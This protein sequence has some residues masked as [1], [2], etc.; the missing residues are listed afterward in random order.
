MVNIVFAP[1]LWCPNKSW[2]SVPTPTNRFIAFSLHFQII[3]LP[4]FHVRVA[5]AST[6]TCPGFRQLFAGFARLT[7]HDVTS[8]I[9]IIKSRNRKVAGLMIN[10]TKQIELNVHHIKNSWVKIV[11]NNQSSTIKFDKM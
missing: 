8:I 3:F 2:E 11:Q 6:K 5:A 10:L 1:S 7:R 4:N 9:I